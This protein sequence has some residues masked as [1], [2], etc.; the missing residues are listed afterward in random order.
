MNSVLNGFE[1]PF[2]LLTAAV[3]SQEH[4]ITLVLY[5]MV[6]LPMGEFQNSWSRGLYDIKIPT[7]LNSL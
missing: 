6:T 4:I 7:R 1:L 3:F 2:A 5:L